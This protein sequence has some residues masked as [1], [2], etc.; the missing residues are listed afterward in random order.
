EDDWLRRQ[1]LS[2]EVVRRIVGELVAALPGDDVENGA[3]DVAVLGRHAD[4]L[5]LN[6]L[7]D[8]DARLGARYACARACEIRAVDEKEVFVAAGPERRHGRHGSARRRR[9]RHAWSGSY[10][11]EH[12][13][14]S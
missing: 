9:R 12:A 13:E 8:V 6:F 4:G 2:L 1:A 14:P 3:L 5:H 7:N 11:I 10:R